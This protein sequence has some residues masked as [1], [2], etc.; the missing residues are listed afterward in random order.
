MSDAPDFAPDRRSTVVTEQSIE[1]QGFS[2]VELLGIPDGDNLVLTLDPG[3][4]KILSVTGLLVD[5]VQNGGSGDHSLQVR[6]D[7]DQ[8]LDSIEVTQPGTEDL[9]FEGVDVP[10]PST[11]TTLFPTSA[12]A[13]AQAVRV[14]RATSAEPVEIRYRNRTGQQSSAVGIQATGVARRIA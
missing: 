4:G 8:I 6:N 2:E 14:L 5:V 12:G 13:R 10:N 11:A 7:L 3:P 1:R 9:R